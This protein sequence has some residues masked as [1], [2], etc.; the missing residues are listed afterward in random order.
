M[1]GSS[2]LTCS[3]IFFWG[4]VVLTLAAAVQLRDCGH[5]LKEKPLTSEASGHWSWGGGVYSGEGDVPCRPWL[6]QGHT[7]R[8]CDPERLC[9][10]T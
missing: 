1:Q 2:V 3:S 8:A 5:D 10:R 9:R 6:L 7:N 4:G